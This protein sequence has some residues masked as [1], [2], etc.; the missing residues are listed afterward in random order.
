MDELF[1]PSSRQLRAIRSW[2]GMDQATFSEK[3]GVS[4]T[5]LVKFE[6]GQK[7]TDETVDMIAR[8]VARMEVAFRKDGGVVLPL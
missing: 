2:F 5:T 1:K 4:V 7:V 3:S 8:Q 6:R